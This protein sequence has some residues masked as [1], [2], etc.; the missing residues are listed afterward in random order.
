LF[1]YVTLYLAI[2]VDLPFKSNQVGDW[3]ESFRAWA[4]ER[5]EELGAIIHHL[6]PYQQ[7]SLIVFF[8][9]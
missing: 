4:P 2:E 8:R 1:P 3:G 7:F 9:S 6:L 5:I